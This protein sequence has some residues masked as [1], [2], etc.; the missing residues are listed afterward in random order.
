MSRCVYRFDTTPQSQYAG[1]RRS[2]PC[3]GCFDVTNTIVGTRRHEIHDISR[4]SGLIGRFAALTLVALSLGL[5]GCESGSSV[6]G[7]TGSTQPETQIAQP[8]PAAV[9]STRVSVAPVIGAPDGIAK[10]LAQ[11]FGAA[12]KQKNVTV[13]GP[14]DKADF[15]LRGYIVAAKD[16]AATKISYIWDVTDQAGRRVNRITGEEIVSGAAGNDPWAGVSPQVTQ[17]I[18]QKAA[19]SLGAWL[20]QQTPAVAAA[21]TAPTPV[22]ANQNT[23]MTPAAVGALQPAKAAAAPASTGPVAAVIP[24]LTGATGDGNNALAA[25]LQ[26]ELSKNGVGSASQGGQPY[27][28][29]GVVKMGSATDGKQPVQIDWSVKDPQGKR[30]GTVTQKNEVAAGS[31]DASWGKTADAAASAAAQGILKLLPHTASN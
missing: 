17:S 26:A 7:A 14:Q 4:F 6:L 11:D 5:A 28:V 22:A 3:R 25:A 1:S 29:E 9:A 23:A 19:G 24:S 13:V 31:L 8:P 21:P 27:R 30:L 10:Q 12:V 2:Y 16:K 15:A 18:A 20:S